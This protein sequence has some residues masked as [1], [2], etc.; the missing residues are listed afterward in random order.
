MEFVEIEQGGTDDT[1]PASTKPLE[2]PSKATGPSRSWYNSRGLNE[3]SRDIADWRH[4]KGFETSWDNMMEKLM[5]VV[6]EL[7]EA[8]EAYR[9]ENRT[10]F[11]EEIADAMIR[12]WDIC[13]S[14]G[15]DLEKELGDKMVYNESRPIKHGKKC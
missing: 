13:G 4:R 1:T 10:N 6:T 14:I 2:A 3:W 12:L 11:D 8:A 15:I 7:G 5:L 9:K